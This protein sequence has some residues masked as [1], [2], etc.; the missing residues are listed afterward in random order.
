MA[1]RKG[2]LSTPH[3]QAV[4]FRIWQHCQQYG[5]SSVHEIAAAI[6]VNASVVGRVIAA[7]GWGDRLEE[8]QSVNRA[9]YAPSAIYYGGGNPKVYVAMGV[10]SIDAP[11]RVIAQRGY[12]TPA[13]L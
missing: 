6:G 12:I 11:R 13:D 7:K 5:W 1:D 4:A 3:M 9:N 8:Y 2:N 10:S